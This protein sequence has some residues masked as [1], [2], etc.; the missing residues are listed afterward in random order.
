MGVAMEVMSLA[1][2]LVSLR[3]EQSV[4]FGTAEIPKRSR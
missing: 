3:R 2:P 1:P 4:I